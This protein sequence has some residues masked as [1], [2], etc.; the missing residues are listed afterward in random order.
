MIDFACKKFDLDDVVKCS[1]G[2]TK[3]E[4]AILDWVSKREDTFTSR[5]IANFLRIDLTTA[6]K[7]ILKL[8]NAGILERGQENLSGGGYVFVYR[9]VG[10]ER[11]RKIIG[12]IVDSWARG[13]KARLDEW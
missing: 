3:M 7:G 9:C 1:L 8:R 10:K 2:L 6:Q 4:Y 11:V 13:V 12:G 5:D